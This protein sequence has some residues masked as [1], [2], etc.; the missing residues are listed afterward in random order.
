MNF[1]TSQNENE[2]DSNPVDLTQQRL[3][4]VEV[5][6][7]LLLTLVIIQIAISLYL[8][9]QTLFPSWTTIIVALLLVGWVGWIFRKQLPALAGLITRRLFSNKP[10][11]FRTSRKPENFE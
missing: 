10:D 1:F 3:R 7:N 5:K 6:V 9:I 11:S 8:A 2:K 4:G